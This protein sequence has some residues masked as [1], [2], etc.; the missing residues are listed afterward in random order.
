MG[1][2]LLQERHQGTHSPAPCEEGT[3]FRSGWVL[4]W[5]KVWVGREMSLDSCHFEPHGSS[6]HPT[7]SVP[8]FAIGK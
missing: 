6:L 8:Q 7:P 1:L 5:A 2:E 4:L 3:I